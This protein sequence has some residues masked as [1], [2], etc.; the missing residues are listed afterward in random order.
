[1]PTWSSAQSDDIVIVATF[2]NGS[3]NLDWYN[4]NDNVMGGRSRGQFEI[5]D[6][7]LNFEGSLNT[8]GGGFA[9]IRT[10]PKSL[11]LDD[12]ERVVLKVRGDGRVYKM[13]LMTEQSRVAY[14]ADFAT[15]ADQWINV[16]LA[17]N[18]FV[19]TWRGQKLNQPSVDPSAI[20]SIGFMIADKLDGPFRLEVKWVGFK[21]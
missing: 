6:Q 1:M 7:Q 8:N 2:A 16:E 12:A 3:A 11:G 13:R 9:S 19:P 17:L 14:S 21:T 20:T 18:D 10:S 4:V 5:L 15:I